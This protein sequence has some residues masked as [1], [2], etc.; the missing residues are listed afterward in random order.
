MSENK[1]VRYKVNT[2]A[3]SAYK[4]FVVRPYLWYRKLTSYAAILSSDVKEKKTSE[5]GASW[6]EEKFSS[7]MAFM[8]FTSVLSSLL[9]IRSS[10]QETGELL[11]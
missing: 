10:H 7:L 4:S 5:E 9:L 6:S 11:C 1:S 3:Q 8:T 2:D